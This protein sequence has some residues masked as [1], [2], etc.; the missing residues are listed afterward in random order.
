MRVAGPSPNT[1]Y[2]R[3]RMPT[4]RSNVLVSKSRYTSIRRPPGR[5]TASPQLDPRSGDDFLAA[6]STFTNRLPAEETALRLVFQC[7]FFRWRSVCRSSNPDFGKTRSAAYRC[8]QIQPPTA[9]LPLVYVA[10]VPTTP[11]LRSSGHCNTNGAVRTGVFV[12]HLRNN[13]SSR[14]IQLRAELKF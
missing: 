6:N 10:W 8:S 13:G 7:R 11:F 12:R 3:S 4:R 5:T 14:M 9:E 2:A 1:A